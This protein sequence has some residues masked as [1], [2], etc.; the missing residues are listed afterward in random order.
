M[1]LHHST[2]S[3]F[4][5]K[6]MVSAIELGLD[7]RIEKVPARV[8]PIDRTSPVIADNPLGKVPTLVDDDGMSLMSTAG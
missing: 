2:T 8:S 3:P 4:V 6:V 7:G 5:R 1:K